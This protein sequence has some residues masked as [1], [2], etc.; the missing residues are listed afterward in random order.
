MQVCKYNF[1]PIRIRTDVRYGNETKLFRFARDVKQIGC[2]FDVNTGR[3]KLAEASM[4]SYV[5]FVLLEL[6]CL[7]LVTTQQGRL[8]YVGR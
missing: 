7:R 1:V 2:Q 4:R 3:L 6:C 8:L 5:V